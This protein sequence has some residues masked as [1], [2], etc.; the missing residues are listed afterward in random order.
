M[1]D[2]RKDMVI[3]SRLNDERSITFSVSKASDVNSIDVIDRIK[4]LIDEYRANIAD[5]IEFSY[6]NDNSVMIIRTIKVL[7]NNAI[8]GMFL[9]DEEGELSTTAVNA[10]F[11]NGK[12]QS[13]ESTYV[14][15]SPQEWDRFMRFMY[16]PKM[17]E[18]LSVTCDLL[19][20]SLSNFLLTVSQG[21]LW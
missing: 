15:N 8:T 17:C 20:Y 2:R 5:G 7:R 12:P 18:G 6:S 13:I 19:T 16:V 14:M 4:A 10:S 3:L 11:A 9:I 1:N 21:T